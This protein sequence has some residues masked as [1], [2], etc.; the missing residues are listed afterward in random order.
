MNLSVWDHSNPDLWLQKR[1]KKKEVNE[2]R[3]L[4]ALLADSL[5]FSYILN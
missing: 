3:L 4:L 1:Q 5:F 2:E